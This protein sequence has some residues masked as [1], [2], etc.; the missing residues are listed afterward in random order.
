MTNF[1]LLA[2]SIS[3]S[4]SGINS[5]RG[6]IDGE[7]ILM[8]YNVK[9]GTLTYDLSDKQFTTAKH[10]LTVVVTDNVGNSKKISAI[11]FRKK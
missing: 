8:E 4:E 3:D 10:E 11:F 9:T 7:W 6:E 5:Y 1:K 2:V